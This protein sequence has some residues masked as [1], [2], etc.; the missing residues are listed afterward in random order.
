MSVWKKNDLTH[1]LRRASVHIIAVPTPITPGFQ[2]DLSFVEDATRFVG[3][4]LK[5]DDIV[6][7]ESTVYLGATEEICIPI[8]EKESGFLCD[9]TFAVGYSPERINPGDP[10]RTVDKI[11]K[12][13]SATS[14]GALDRLMN[15]YNRLTGGL[16]HPAPSIKAAEASK[17]MENA[18]H[19]I[20][21]AFI[22][23]AAVIFEKIGISSHEVLELAVTKWNF[24][25]FWP[26][27]VRGHCI[28]V[29]P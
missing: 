18:Q 25:P 24:R 9:Q 4:I 16:A 8:L 19:D 6:C 2:P 13:V 22:N 5:E 17:V 21:I 23:E 10:L 7:F 20:N 11:D 3:S 26:G 1:L 15:I 14:A 12:I 28:G 27:L 29:D